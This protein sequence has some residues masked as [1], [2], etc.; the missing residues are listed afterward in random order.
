MCDLAT[1]IFCEPGKCTLVFEGSD[2]APRIG[3]APLLG[4]EVSLGEACER[5]MDIGRFFDNCAPTLHCRKG[6]CVQM[7]DLETPACPAGLTCT[8]HPDL[9]VEMG[10]IWAGLCE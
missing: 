9:F 4:V 6:V 7:C 10:T 5:V 2:G 1:G 3:C 8:S